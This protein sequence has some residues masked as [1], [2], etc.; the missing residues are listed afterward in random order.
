MG[1]APHVHRLRLANLHLKSLV[2][3]R[4]VFV[5]L[6]DLVWILCTWALGIVTSNLT[7]PRLP[8]FHHRRH[9]ISKK[10]I[11][12]AT[13]A[14]YSPP[15]RPPAGARP[16]GA[17]PP[18]LGLSAPARRSS[19]SWRPP[20]GARPLGAR[21]PEF[22]LGARPSEVGLSAPARRGMTSQRPPAGA[23]P[24]RRPP[25]L[26][27]SALACRSLTAPARRGTTSQHP[28]ARARPRRPPAGAHPL[29]AHA[30]ELDRAHPPELGLDA[31]L[32]LTSTSSA[33][34]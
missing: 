15:R 29:G 28:P 19:P 26:T 20:A 3:L 32:L 5:G 31:S 14:P 21:S 30:P 9:G 16:L 25:E 23:R 4:L 22:D 24:R 8:R 2:Q 34:R 18:E 7:P 10:K 11:T 17:C 13:R 27:L 12:T 1:Q 33:R 6:D